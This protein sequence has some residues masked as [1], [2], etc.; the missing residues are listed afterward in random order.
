MWVRGHE[1]VRKRVRTQA[2]ARK[3]GLLLRRQTGIGTPQEP[4]GAGL[5][6]ICG[7]IGRLMD[8]WGR[9][10]S[11][12]GAKWRPA[13]FVAQ[14]LIAKLPEPRGLSEQASSTGRK[15][16][17]RCSIYTPKS[18][19][20]TSSDSSTNRVR[21]SS[22]LSHLQNSWVAAQLSPPILRVNTPLF[23]ISTACSGPEGPA[24]RQEAENKGIDGVFHR[25]SRH[26]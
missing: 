3:I 26:R 6:A 19:S 12:W 22:L 21:K 8:R 10:T 17:F 20:K 11:A 16:R 1:N 14:S 25:A 4:A 15:G 9:L 7:L 13:A 5:S 18:L 24:A 2:A 23:W